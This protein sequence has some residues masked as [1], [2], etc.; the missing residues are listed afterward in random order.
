[1]SKVEISNEGGKWRVAVDDGPNLAP[2]IRAGGIRVEFRDAP[3]DDTLVHITLRA[4]ELNM[5]LAN[6]VVEASQML[7][8]D[9][10]AGR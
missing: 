6:A 7:L 5:S 9:G 3:Y 4:S 10:E 1:M 2:A 8:A